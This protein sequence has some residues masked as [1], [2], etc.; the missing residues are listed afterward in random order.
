MSQEQDE[1][2]L[3]KFERWLA[4]LR[5]ASST[6][7][8]YLADLRT[9]LRWGHIEFG[10]EF[11]LTGVN[12]EHIRLYRY[13]LTQQVNRAPSTVNRHLMALRKFFAYAQESG[14]ILINPT[15]GVALVQQDGQAVSRP[16]TKEEAEK[17]LAAAGN[18][19]RAGLARR[20]VAILSLLLHTGLR[21]SEIADLRREDMIFDNPGLR[22]QVRNGA[23]NQTRYLPLCN[24]VCKTLNNYLEIRP[25]TEHTEH[26]FLNQQGHA[27]SDRT[28][29]RIINDSA[30][31][32][33]LEGISAQSLRR[34]F[35]LQLLTETND[36][37]LVSKRLGHQ[38]SAIT[39]QYLAVHENQNN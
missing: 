37:D 32:A 5:L 11:A 27:V 16:L 9:F 21:V 29:Q 30:K 8:N 3:A 20:D 10:P 7:V 36:L 15:G 26:L 2:I 34:T 6:I 28:I 18:G 12:Q 17:L 39:A 14:A 24:E 22:L 38:N 4:D 25:R 19:S 13:Y 31:T 35:A 1:I 23:N 33:G